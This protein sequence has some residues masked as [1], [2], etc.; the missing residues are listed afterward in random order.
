[1]SERYLGRSSLLA[2]AH[3]LPAGILVKVRSDGRLDRE[4]AALAELAI[5]LDVPVTRATVKQ[6]QRGRVKVGPE[7]VAYGSV[8]FFAQL[9]GR[10]AAR[11]PCTNPTP[12][13]SLTSFTGASNALNRCATP[14]RDSTTGNGFL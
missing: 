5:E 8:D 3:L 12:L 4:E 11:Y 9:Y 14:A 1:M 10:P 6:V 2:E 13:P 7:V